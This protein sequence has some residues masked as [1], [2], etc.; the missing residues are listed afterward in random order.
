M[1]LGIRLRTRTCTD[2]KSLM[3]KHLL[4]LSVILT[5]ATGCDNVAWGGIDVDV[6]GTPTELRSRYPALD[7]A[8]QNVI[9][10]RRGGDISGQ[11]LG[12]YMLQ[13][14]RGENLQRL[15]AVGGDDGVVALVFEERSE[16]PTHVVL[17]INDENELVR[18]SVPPR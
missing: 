12:Q 13:N 17:V 4:A 3:Q 18:H 7:S 8:I 10:I 9:H 15:L 1:K 14:S 6:I 5:V 11:Q 16:K 2:P